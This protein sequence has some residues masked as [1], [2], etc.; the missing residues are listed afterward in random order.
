MD[1]QVMGSW[2]PQAGDECVGGA[3]GSALIAHF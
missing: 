1:W 2:D 3:L